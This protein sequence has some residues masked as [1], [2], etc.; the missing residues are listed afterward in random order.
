MSE[1]AIFNRNIFDNHVEERPIYNMARGWNDS[2]SRWQNSTRS[3]V[4]T[5]GGYWT[6]STRSWVNDTSGGRWSDSGSATGK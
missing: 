6:N 1:L 2:A 3:W 4:N 5:G